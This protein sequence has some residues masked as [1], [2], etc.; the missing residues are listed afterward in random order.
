M[1]ALVYVARIRSSLAFGDLAAGLSELGE[2]ENLFV[3]GTDDAPALDAQRYKLKR[4]YSPEALQN[5]RAMNNKRMAERTEQIV[6]T[7]ADILR[8]NAHAPLVKLVSL[9]NATDVRPNPRGQPWSERS[10]A[11]HLDQALARIT[12]PGGGQISG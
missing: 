11:K 2:V 9:M 7:L 8:N 10:L 3:K 5:L 1:K 6:T 12:Q 4:Q